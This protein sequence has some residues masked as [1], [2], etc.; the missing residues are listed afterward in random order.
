MTAPL[1]QLNQVLSFVDI[2][3]GETAALSHDINI[4]GRAVVPDIVFR[5]NSAFSIV[6]VTASLVT[7]RNDGDGV[8][9]LNV[10]LQRQHTIDRA[11]GA[12]QTT[13]L[14]PHPFVPAVGGSG[15]G[16]FGPTYGLGPTNPG[17]LQPAFVTPETTVT[18]YARTTGN[19]SFGD[20][21]LVNPYRTLVR[22]V[23]DVPSL[24]PP[25]LRYI[26]DITGIT[27]SL[28]ID[29]ELPT[30]KAAEQGSYAMTHPYF[31][32]TAAVTIQAEPQLVAAIPPADAVVELADIASQVASPNTGLILL[33]LNA[34]RAS[35]AGNALKGK[36]VVMAAGHPTPA[37][38]NTT[39]LESTDTTLLL[40]TATTLSTG[41]SIREPSAA[42]AVTSVPTA[43]GNR[44]GLNAYNIDS[45]AFNG[46]KITTV[47]GGASFGLVC[48]GAGQAVV[49]MCELQNPQFAAIS[50]NLTKTF[51]NWIYGARVRANGLVALV[52]ALCENIGT[53]ALLNMRLLH[54]SRCGIFGG[55]TFECVAQA[56]GSTRFPEPTT[57]RIEN[58]L[59]RNIVGATADGIRFNGG[60]AQFDS[61]EINGCG[62]DGIR[63]EDDVG[64]L[65]LN[66]VRCTV[67][68]G[69]TTASGVGIRVNDGIQVWVNAA[70]SAAGDVLTGAGGDMQVGGLAVRTWADF[71]DAA[72]P[73]GRAQFNEFDIEDPPL[74]TT[75]GSRLFQR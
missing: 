34:P 55:V 1:T 72:P 50:S 21:S 68:N 18:I 26:V 58:T 32:F 47:T 7:V 2:G 63:C 5:D 35:W 16:D 33:T 31:L 24:V 10:W 36:F 52:G 22:A 38:S 4:N 13:E 11:Y 20:G 41:F 73:S 67:P 57:L 37:Q 12:D 6:S 59:F 43:T 30:W 3:A 75:T 19:D 74:S 23:R 8:G 27:E 17:I 42:L 66:N 28:P 25:G 61:V 70:T 69:V 39:I 53:W 45:I 60:K 71:I 46:L 49:Q 48:A 51:N 54:V 40:A 44:G 14:V 62:R 9:T 15:D 29:Y 56:P 64:F 65:R